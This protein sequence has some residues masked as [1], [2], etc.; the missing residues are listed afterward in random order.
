MS[1]LPAVAAPRR[2][3]IEFIDL[4][5]GWAVIVMI[6]THV[7]NAMLNAESAAGSLFQILTFVNGLVAPSFL[8]ASG[9]AYAVTTRRK[10]RE[11]LSFAP[12]LYRQIGRLLFVILIGYSLHVPRF[13]YYHLRYVAG[14]QAWN[15]F[16][17]PDVL[18]CIGVSL[19]IIQGMLLL[20]RTERRLYSALGVLTAAVV[21]LSPVVWG[22][23]FWTILPVPIASYFN[24]QHRALFP[25]FPWSAFLFAGAISGYLYVQARDADP[26]RSGERQSAT[27]GRLAWAAAAMVAVSFAIG[28]I[29]RVVIPGYAFWLYGPDFFLM[30][31]GFV[32]LFC[33]GLFWFEK[34]RGLSQHSPVTLIGRESLLVYTVHLI[35]IYGK[36]GSVTLNE[37]VNR[38]FGYLEG[39]LLSLAL[40]LSMYLLAYLWDRIK[41]GPRRWKLAVELSLAAYLVGVFFFGSGS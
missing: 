5:R 18:Q 22:Y 17:Q 21:L 20:L 29:S 24:G 8:F 3:R 40:I 37:K 4:L 11:Y 1:E 32:L 33:A 10:L 12:P 30:R 28:P 36:F 39:I 41:H 16:F 26:D 25:L 7:M 23:D 27:M 14:E 9:L 6:E 13:N 34:K 31:L 2:K 15:D 35:A 38:S 19:L